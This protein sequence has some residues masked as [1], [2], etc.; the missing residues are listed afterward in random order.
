ME[1]KAL[2]VYKIV[3]L[4]NYIGNVKYLYLVDKSDTF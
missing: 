1:G 4:S 2:L 3:F